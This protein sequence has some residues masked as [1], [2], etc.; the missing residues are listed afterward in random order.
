MMNKI[1]RNSFGCV[2]LWGMFFFFPTFVLKAGENSKPIP[3]PTPGEVQLTVPFEKQNT[4][5]ECGLSAAKMVCGFY[6][7]KMSGTWEDWLLAGSKGRKGIL[8]SELVIA[9]NS[10]GYD[11]AVFSGTVDRKITGLYYHLDKGR[12]LIVMITSKDGKNSHYDVV[13]GYNQPKSQISVLDPALGPL[14]LAIKDFIPAWSRA[15]YFT[16]VA[17]PAQLMNQTPVPVDTPTP[18]K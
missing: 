12:P 13:T 11:T 6:G 18:V 16:L 4:P 15:N 2:Y 5:N 8:G 1:F 9:F 17:V 3:A 14:I 10:M 7:Q